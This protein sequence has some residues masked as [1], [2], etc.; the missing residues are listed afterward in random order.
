VSD[1]ERQT[2]ETAAADPAERQPSESTVSGA[3]V[4]SPGLGSDTDPKA[5]AAAARGSTAALPGLDKLPPAAQRT[6]VL[7]GVAFAGSFFLARVLKRIFD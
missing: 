2:T 7:V 3:R 5:A 1:D 6:E 4:A